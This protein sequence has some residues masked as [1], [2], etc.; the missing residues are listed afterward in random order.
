MSA[1]KGLRVGLTGGIGAGKSVVASALRELGAVVVDADV[2]A[3]E[4]V[5]PGSDGLGDIVAAFGDDILA[6][7]GSLDRDAMA[8]VVFADPS[9]R[10]RLE[11]IIHPRVRERAAAIEAEIR[12]RDASAVVVHDIPLLVETGQQGAYDIVLV[13]DVPIEVQL[14]RLVR[15]RG[16][17]LAEARA[18]IGA[19]ADRAT[20]LAAADVV[21]DNSGTLD[22][23]ARRVRQVWEEHLAC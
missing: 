6:E 11:A 9:A 2:L 17:E 10:G 7:D 13:V 22:D 3:R 18:R 5:A 23:M 4:A 21:V 16:M 1:R 20:R 19:Q 8:Q 15:V 14:D 12:A